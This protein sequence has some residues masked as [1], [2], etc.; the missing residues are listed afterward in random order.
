MLHLLLGSNTVDEYGQSTLPGGQIVGR[1]T[2]AAQSLKKK[3]GK[4]LNLNKTTLMSKFILSEVYINELLP[5]T[6][7]EGYRAGCGC[8]SCS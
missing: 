4:V 5:R 1:D 6:F 7:R 2:A 3:A 8:T